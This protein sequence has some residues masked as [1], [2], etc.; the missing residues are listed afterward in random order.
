MYRPD[1]IQNA[2]SSGSMGMKYQTV[3]ALE[4]S[5]IRLLP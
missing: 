2:I 3:I 1:Y 5:N 4:Q